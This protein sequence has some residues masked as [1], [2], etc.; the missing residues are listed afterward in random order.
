MRG[1]TQALFG[2]L[3]LAALNTFGDFVWARFITAHRPLFGLL[4]GMALC[5]AIGLYLGG[6]RR[7]PLRGAVAGALIGLGAAGGYYLL[8]RLMGIS[9]MFV[10]WMA[11]WAAFGLLSGRG[12][13]DPRSSTAAALARGGLAALGSGLAFYTI[14]GIWTRPRPGGPDY[15]YHFLCWTVAFLPGFLALLVRRNGARLLKP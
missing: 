15:A 11:L 3:L 5:L 8:A 7:H 10:L 1:V 6:L 9:A 14:S 12:L 4:H 13:G 2:S